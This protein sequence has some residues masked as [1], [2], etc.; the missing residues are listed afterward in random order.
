MLPNRRGLLR[1]FNI[2]SSKNKICLFFFNFLFTFCL[3]HIEKKS[4]CIGLLR[5]MR[6]LI[7]DQ[8][9]FL[10][11][12]IFFFFTIDVF[13]PSNLLFTSP[14]TILLCFRGARSFFLLVISYRIF[15]RGLNN[16]RGEIRGI[17]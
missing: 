2:F 14:L 6:P 5:D 10:L 9:W 13:F 15:Y 3:Y 17:E 8:L 4:F 11:F 12:F 1:L 16:I 7:L